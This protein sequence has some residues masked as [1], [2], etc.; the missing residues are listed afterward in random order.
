M[1]FYGWVSQQG[2]DFNDRN[3]W[4]DDT[5]QVGPP[6]GP[7]SAGDTVSIGSDSV[8]T[9]TA[10]GNTVGFMSCGNQ[11]TITGAL[12][13]DTFAGGIIGGGTFQFGTYQ[14]SV[15]NS[16]TMQATTINN[17][18]INGGQIT[19]ADLELV[20]VTAGTI[21]A[22][23][24]F[25]TVSGGAITASTTEQSNLD[26]GTLQTGSIDGS[27]INGATVT[28]QSLG[29]GATVVKSGSLSGPVNL[30]GGG[31][32][33]VSGGTVSASSLTVG[34]AMTGSLSVTGGQM[35]VS[36]ASSIANGTV[37][38]KSGGALTLQNALTITSASAILDIEAGGTATLTGDTTVD[39]P[40]AG[41]EIQI[42][43]TGATLQ[44]NGQL[45]LGTTQTGY[46]TIG[47]GGH[48]VVTGNILLGSGNTAS[49]GIVALTGSSTLEAGNLTVGGATPTA[50]NTDG[51]PNG[52]CGDWVTVGGTGSLQLNTG[53]YVAVDHTLTLAD[54]S[55][56]GMPQDLG[57]LSFLGG[58]IEVGG[59][60]GGVIGGMRV[61]AGGLVIGHGQLSDLANSGTIEAQNGTLTV[62][63]NVTGTGLAQIDNNAT[64]ALVGSFT[65]TV[66][67][68]G[69]YES[70]LVLYQA[71]PN[72]QFKG[73]IS[74]LAIGDTIELAGTLP[75]KVRPGGVPPSIV[76]HTQINGTIL[77]VT[78]S[79]NTVWDYQLANAL[80]GD[81]FTIRD[82]PD[83]NIGLTLEQSS[84]KITTGISGQPTGNPYL[85]S[86]IGGWGA[87][88]A[89]HGPITYW[90]GTPGDVTAAT[91][92]HGETNLLQCGQTVD[93]WADIANGAAEQDYVK[94]LQD[95][96]AVT[97]LTFQQATSAAT[98]N[99]VCWL[100]PA[101]DPSQVA[102]HS[103][104]PAQVTDGQLWQ[105]F[106][107]VPWVNDPNELAFGGRDST[108]FFTS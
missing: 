66:K 89:S 7:P 20:V 34:G 59:H 71:N 19:A 80:P 6:A 94:A 11:I 82:L 26:G 79:D 40:L 73:A 12:T 90:F 3:N 43:G 50:N 107:D 55:D 15:M 104:V 23:D 67:F 61:D 97:G 35:T 105:Y 10:D 78:F 88:N 46:M 39:T 38:V 27:L 31:S 76:A 47:G 54:P 102:G 93:N 101:L 49:S 84:P 1:T 62:N 51:Q 48:V 100:D 44:E 32:L 64:L 57:G 72:T 91:N 69:G 8:F 98:A 108:R 96:S 30:Q 99:I 58:S 9:V 42:N 53:S 60:S 95:Y 83:G 4:E 14:S 29:T 24:F 28:E 2:G 75:T 22:G 16:G 25:G 70:T 56:E 17:V 77:S 41:A 106:D 21:N 37:L 33:G 86:L 13:A 5:N 36:G 18:F 68:N 63:G 103:E 92:I 81:C 74:G 45:I 87:W 65:G 85:D 52:T